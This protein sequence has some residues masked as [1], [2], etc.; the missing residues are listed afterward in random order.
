MGLILLQLIN[1]L[2]KVLSLLALVGFPHWLQ[3]S[4]QA[5][6]ELLLLF[7][8][9]FNGIVLKLFR[10]LPKLKATLAGLCALLDSPCH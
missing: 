6:N 5:K 4:R 1:F 9:M 8:D 10:A 7:W 3:H 2:H